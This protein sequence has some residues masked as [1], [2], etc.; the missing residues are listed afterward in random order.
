VALD[1]V[2]GGDDVGH[3]FDGCQ[4]LEVEGPDR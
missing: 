4:A 3:F 1:V 2:A